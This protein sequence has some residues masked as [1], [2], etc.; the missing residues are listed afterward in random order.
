[1][2][3]ILDYRQILNRK[4]ALNR[5]LV[6]EWVALPG[7]AGGKYFFD[8]CG[9]N[10]GTLTNG[11]TWQGPLGRPG[12]FGSLKFGNDTSNYV[13]ATTS[14][15]LTT[16]WTNSAWIWIHPNATNSSFHEI[17]S[18][19]GGFALTIFKD[20]TTAIIRYFDGTAYDTGFVLSASR[21][22]H[23]LV[24]HGTG[25]NLQIWIDGVRQVNTAKA[26]VSQMPVDGIGLGESSGRYWMGYLDEIRI[27]AAY[28]PDGMVPYLESRLGNPNRYNWIDISKL[29][30]VQIRELY[31]R[32]NMFKSPV[33]TGI[34]S[35]DDEENQ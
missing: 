6:S 27:T 34:R 7:L 23:V 24:T 19:Q 12:G 29:T 35:R 22:H 33:L 9:Q 13:A 5:G 16:G 15:T 1:M 10:H 17:V 28:T 26:T 11:P 2:N 31:Y 30:Q 8:V 4:H 18:Y 25:Q 32:Y 3:K 20:T 14:A 21:W